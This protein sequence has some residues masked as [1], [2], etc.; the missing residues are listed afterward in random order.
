MQKKFTSLASNCVFAIVLLLGIRAGY[1]QN[2][3]S[4]PSF[5]DFFILPKDFTNVKYKNTEI[6]PKWFFLDTPDYFH[7]KCSSKITGVPRNFAGSINPMQGRGYAGL[8]LRADPDNYKFSPRYSEHLQNELTEKMKPGQ[9]YCCKV[10]ISLAKNSGFAVDGFGILFTDDPIRFEEKDDVLRYRPHIENSHGNILLH[11]GNWML[12]SGIYKAKGGEQYM[13][14]GNFRPLDET[15][16]FRL[17]MKLKS[18]INYFS[19][20]YLDN[21]SVEPIDNVDECECTA[22]SYTIQEE[23]DWYASA[24][25]TPLDEISS[26]EDENFGKIEFGKPVELKNIYFDFDKF[27]LLS[28]SFVELD[29]LYLLI[30]KNPD[31]L[32]DIA[33]HTDSLGG[34]DYNKRLSENRAKAVMD[35]LVNKGVDKERIVYHGYGSTVPIATNETEEGRQNNRRVEFVIQKKHGEPKEVNRTADSLN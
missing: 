35:Y 31:F 2:I 24:T 21:I 9:L 19:Y 18:K 30:A 32:I 34:F 33:G 10:Y 29:K 1:G 26:Y 6:I 25:E 20:Y 7:K 15:S 28:K 27:D 22:L 3:V 12:F 5:E 4:N 13:T 14:L 23:F 17:K 16:I 11:N 8:I